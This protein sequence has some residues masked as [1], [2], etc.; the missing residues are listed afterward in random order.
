MVLSSSFDNL[1]IPFLPCQLMLLALDYIRHTI[2]FGRGLL[3]NS[4][5]CLPSVQSDSFKRFDKYRLEPVNPLSLIARRYASGST[6]ID[7]YLSLLS[8][9]YRWDTRPLP[10]PKG[11]VLSSCAESRTTFDTILS[12]GCVPLYLGYSQ[13][14]KT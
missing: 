9:F 3:I 10:I 12:H 13:F 8:S 4:L 2:C 6:T 1:S 5:P 7:T 11:L 14:K